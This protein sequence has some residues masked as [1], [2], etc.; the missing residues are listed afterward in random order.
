MV[1]SSAIFIFGFL[2]LMLAVYFV[3]P[4]PLRNV[5]LLVGSLFFYAWGEV[6]FVGV[7]LASIAANYAFGRLIDHFRDHRQNRLILALGVGTNLL[8]LGSYKYANFLVDSLNVPLGAVGISPMQLDPVH[9]PIGISFFTFQALSYLVDVYRSDAPVSRNLFHVALYISM[10]PQLIAGPIVRYQ[11]VAEQIVSRHV[12][13]ALFASGVR[14]FIIGLGKKVLIANPL[15]EVADQIF[16]LSGGDLTTGLAWLG[17]ACYTLQIYFDFSGYSDMAIGLGKMFGFRFPENFNYP[18]ISLSIREFW[19]RWHISLSSW[20]RD[21]LYIPMGGNKKGRI[22]THLNLVIVFFL[23]GL[24]H[25]ASWNFVIW[26]LLHGVFLVL[27][28]GPFG[29]LMERLPRPVGHG[30]T[31]LVVMVGWVFF[32]IESFPDALTHLAAMFGFA[33]GSGET[34]HAGYYL[35]ADVWTILIVGAVCMLPVLPWLQERIAQA[36]PRLVLALEGGGTVA[37]FAVFGV[38]LTSVAA[39]TYDPFI[40]FRF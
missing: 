14:R 13:M 30:Y 12:D 19:R 2:P 32:R 27:E 26:G 22:R 17:I 8:L 23:C 31:L 15:G 24:W 18:Y 28:R 35:T 11:Q 21:Y 5:V 9:L 40:Y 6:F 38:T 34:F 36:S 25:G 7:L 20:F 33:Q 4:K 1:F 39:G 37:L 10:F 16:A 29:Q 3:A